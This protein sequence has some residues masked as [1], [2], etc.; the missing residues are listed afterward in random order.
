MASTKFV[1][2]VVIEFSGEA[3]STEFLGLMDHSGEAFR[4]IENYDYKK[5]ISE[6]YG[7]PIEFEKDHRLRHMGKDARDKLYFDEIH[8]LSE[9]DSFEDPGI[10]ASVHI[11][12]FEV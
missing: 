2:F 5:S 9:H 7:F 1:V 3:I 12:M 4:A 11:N 10:E 6:E 8:Y